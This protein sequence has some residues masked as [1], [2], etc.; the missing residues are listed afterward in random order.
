LAE[1]GIKIG[2]DVGVAGF[3]DIPI[4]HYMS[5][6]LTTINSRIAELGAQATERLIGMIAGN[7]FEKNHITLVPQLVARDSTR[8]TK[9]RPRPVKPDMEINA[10][11]DL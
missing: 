9:S 3:D 10:V 8:R 5:P 6:S 2:E 1:A 4:A 11:T 7:H